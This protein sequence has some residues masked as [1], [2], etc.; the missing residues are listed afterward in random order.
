MVRAF[1]E[2]YGSYSIVGHSQ[3]GLA[4][5]HLKTYYWSGLD[6]VGSGRSIQSVGSPY[7]GCS[8]AGSLAGIGELFG[9]GCGTN[10]DLSTDGAS[11]WI[12]KIPKE[13]QNAIYYWNTIN[14]ESWFSF[15]SCVTASGLVL[16]TPNDGTCEIKFSKPP[17]GGT[18]MG[19]KQAWCHTSGMNYPPQ[20]TDK[21]RNTEMN[22]KAAR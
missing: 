22:S 5:L 11:L 1:G 8:L 18:W 21:T 20:C 14:T 2:P 12:A 17:L 13:P 6:T 15:T 10:F 4:S 19:T 7:L 3:G 9:A 16:Y